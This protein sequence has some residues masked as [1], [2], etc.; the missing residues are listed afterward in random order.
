MLC[1]YL[2]RD[3]YI[4]CKPHSGLLLVYFTSDIG[5][6]LNGD[7]CWEAATTSQ[8]F[9]AF[10]IHLRGEAETDPLQ[11]VRE[12]GVGD[13]RQVGLGKQSMVAHAL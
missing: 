8:Q 9:Q 5:A 1:L 12:E 6:I 10:V 7:G 4:C 3:I 2:Q 11:G 13:G